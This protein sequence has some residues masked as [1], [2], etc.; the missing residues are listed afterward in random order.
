LTGYG[1]GLVAAGGRL[2]DVNREAEGEFESRQ[3]ASRVSFASRSRSVS[4]LA[5][6]DLARELAPP[7]S[8]AP[9]EDGAVRSAGES[10]AE[11]V[12]DD[13]GALVIKPLTIKPL[14]SEPD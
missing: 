6:A 14:D 12:N 13:A 1:D 3:G 11:G 8:V 10:P 2:L 7:T 4:R 5:G 9:P